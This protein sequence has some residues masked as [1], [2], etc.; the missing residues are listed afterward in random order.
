MEKHHFE[1]AKVWLTG[2]NLVANLDSG[3]DDRHAV[4]VA[5]AGTVIV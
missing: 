1:Q 4:A 5:M 3:G 2:A